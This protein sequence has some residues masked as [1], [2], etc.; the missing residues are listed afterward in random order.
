VVEGRTH[1]SLRRILARGGE[2]R[3]A[4]AALGGLADKF[5]D[6]TEYSKDLVAYGVSGDMAY[7]V[8]HERAAIRVDGDPVSII[9]G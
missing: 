3:G 1:G 2:L 8:G 5:S 4:R 9:S 6:C 7:T